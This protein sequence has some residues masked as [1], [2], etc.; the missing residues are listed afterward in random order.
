M[1]DP[2]H[3]RVCPK[4]CTAL[5]PPELSAEGLCIQHFMVNVERA[6]AVMRQEIAAKVC[7]TRQTEIANNV[8]AVAVKLVLVS[9]G[10]SRVSDEMKKRVLTTLLTL[11]VLRENVNLNPRGY[12]AHDTH[13]VVSSISSVA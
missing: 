12:V 6:C 7:A 8:A 11:M 5:I 2:S 9:T 3:Q 1:S 13:S 10:S 4:G